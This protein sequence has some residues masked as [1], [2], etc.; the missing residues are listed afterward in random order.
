MRRCLRS[1]INAMMLAEVGTTAPNPFVWPVIPFPALVTG[2]LTAVMASLVI[3]VAH[4]F[5][6]TR[7][8]LTVSL[9]VLMAFIIV[10]VASLIYNVPQTPIVDILIG[11]LATALGAVVA[12]WV[13][14]NGHE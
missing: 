6:Q 3:V 2:S 4:Y 11:A 14:R 7:G 10:V 1:S 9:L 13:G 12:H 8:L 5:D